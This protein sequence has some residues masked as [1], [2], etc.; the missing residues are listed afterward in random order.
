MDSVNV[1]VTDQEIEDLA[2]VLDGGTLPADGTLPAG[3]LL[4]SLV[5]AIRAAAAAE[6][7]VTVAVQV[8]ESLQGTFDN[9]FTPEPPADA[10][11]AEFHAAAGGTTG[12]QVS[13]RFMK[14]GRLG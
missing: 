3:N 1:S 9:S 6:Q 7:S 8:V 2:T 13:V 10:A 14:I 5:D 11:V 12:K 4:R